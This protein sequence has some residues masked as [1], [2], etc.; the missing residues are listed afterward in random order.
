[1]SPVARIVERELRGKLDT[2][3]LSLDF[4]S[5]YAADVSGRARAFRS[6]AG[7]DATIPPDEA[8]RLAGLT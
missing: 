4:V 6:L 5:L 1:M 8:R 7:K 3:A 2:P